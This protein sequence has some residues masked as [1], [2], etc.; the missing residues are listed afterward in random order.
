MKLHRL[1][2]EGFGPYRE[3][4]T[5]DFDAFADDGIFLIA[6]R[7]GAGKSSI[8]DG[9]C[10]ALYGGVPRYDGSEKRLR[11]DHCMPD[12]ATEVV[13]EF[14]VAGVRWRATRAPEYE[15]PKRR[16]DG[17]TTEC[18]RAQLDEFVDGCWTGR[19]AGPRE[20]ALALDE[21][22][23]LSQQQFLQVILLAQN[24]FQRFLLARNDERQALL[25]TL[26]GT[27]TYEE[28][29]TAL[30]Q[31]RKDTEA[32]VATSAER[33]ALH[34]ADAED[35]VTE[36]QLAGD[37][38]PHD[39]TDGRIAAAE[40]AARR[41][42]YRAETTAQQRDDAERA[43]RQASEAHAEAV[44]VRQRLKQ[45]DRSRAAL[46]Q[47]LDAEPMIA[48]DRRALERAVAAEALRAPIDA[49]ERA[50]VAY[51][52]AA[53]AEASARAMWLS[54]GE[55]SVA[56]AE[57]RERVDQLGSE[58]ALARAALV[59]E[60]ALAQHEETLAGAAA[61]VVDLER[62]LADQE[63]QCAA[64]PPLLL[65]LDASLAEAAVS[66][67]ALGG[68]TERRDRLADKVRAA[69]EAETLNS[70]M[71]AAE[72]AHLARSRELEA[73]VAAVTA[74]LQR[75]LAGY[76]GELAAGL[77]DG[78]P[79]TVCGATAHPNPA[80]HT[81]PVTDEAVAAAESARDAAATAERSASDAARAARAAHAAAAQRAGGASVTELDES[82]AAAHAAVAAAERA[83]TQHDALIGQREE[84]IAL[85]AAA[86]AERAALAQAISGAREAAAAARVRAADLRR[87]VAA[88][89]GV[90]A[91][92]IERVADLTRRRE[93]GRALLA[94]SDEY[95]ARATAAAD[96]REDRDAR[97][98]AS[99]F[100][101]DIAATAA[102]RDDAGRR[103]LDSRIRAHETALHSERDRLRELEL[104]LAGVGDEAVDVAA[105]ECAAGVARQGW[106]AAVTAA[107]TAFE[108]SG[109]LTR[110][111]ERASAAR[112]EIAE[113]AD[114]HDAVTRL[115]NT[116]AG[117]APNTHRMTL[118]T[119]V[120]AAEL[121][122]IV[123][124]ANRRLAD[125]SSGRYRLRHTD[126]R[127]ARNAA[128][129]LGIE[130]LDA[131]TGHAR[132]AQSL[133][134][135]ETFLASLALALGLAEVVTNRAG[136]LRLDTLFIDEGF[137]SLDAETL[138]LA[139]TT[140]DELRQGGRTVGVISHVEAMKEQ[141]PAQ[142]VVE[143][144]SA[145]P[146]VIRQGVGT[147]V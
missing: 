62:A 74:L 60:R 128:S 92:V 91:S 53:E 73:A 48:D 1:E 18:A 121:E 8:L 55:S 52:A 20:V 38:T 69:R 58:L 66:G 136:G 65:R 102:L 142:L 95:H 145:G 2:L 129:G 86:D 36:H 70:A 84:L 111:V 16:G 6:G 82:L 59:Q 144:S 26:F 3:R 57:L 114:E 29:E 103:A 41:A 106:D 27:R 133:S 108:V 71:S 12:T 54:A 17:V 56:A 44:A 120:L 42:A 94:A 11:S 104:D 68:A 93:L 135:G 81:D 90:F 124:A 98:A 101:D 140:L 23:G 45:R 130:V 87:D 112:D 109:R 63:T 123:D 49:A 83:L 31:R 132:P 134:G 46:G 10:F 79:C 137:G 76:A 61:R 100:A 22:L 139:M 99:A 13:L 118:E 115:A 138:D 34:L 126:T 32:A 105:A 5:V 35:L 33:I 9:V 24:R 141:L 80:S 25:R 51:A 147:L 39:T 89:C 43:H 4:Q 7:T 113:L 21:I 77:I 119:F 28:Y 116:V 131:Y 14:T 50:Q 72:A 15:R 96:T 110:I 37:D 30:E 19:A 127:A 85:Q 47:L 117:R 146:S 88:A 67:A 75:R 107:A 78:E 64:I 122:Q 40:R 97:I 143:A 125:M